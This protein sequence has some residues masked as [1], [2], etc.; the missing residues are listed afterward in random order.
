MPTV[1]QEGVETSESADSSLSAQA[2][3]SSSSSITEIATIDTDTEDDVILIAPPV[4]VIEV[5]TD[6]DESPDIIWMPSSRGQSIPKPILPERVS[7]R[8]TTDRS[9]GL[10]G[11]PPILPP[12]QF[13]IDDEIDT[14]LPVE[15]LLDDLFNSH[16]GTIDFEMPS[17][18]STATATMVDA[19]LLAQDSHRNQSITEQIRMINNVEIAIQTEISCSQE[20][21]TQTDPLPETKKRK[22]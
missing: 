13:E 2:T 18:E 1:N 20:V 19:K 7:S 5:D 10:I 3:T 16:F 14:N 12:A 21:A 22:W 17:L 6:N 9:A 8:T 15:R 4:E 11:A